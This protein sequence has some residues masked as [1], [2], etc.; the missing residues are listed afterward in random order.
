MN[1]LAVKRK[2]G[3][4]N[5]VMKM[6]TY[7][8]HQAH[9]LNCYNVI[10][11]LRCNVQSADESLKNQKSLEHMDLV[12]YWFIWVTSWRRTPLRSRGKYLNSFLC[13]TFHWR[14]VTALTCQWLCSGLNAQ[15]TLFVGLLGFR[16]ER[17]TNSWKQT[18]KPCE[19]G[20]TGHGP[21]T[22]HIPGAKFVT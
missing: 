16:D 5:H 15:P 7:P 3:M 19:K 6:L 17:C 18:L 22:F 2:S 11:N 10:P 14:P 12:W 4:R 8:Q 1:F 9:L 20:T 21:A 13:A